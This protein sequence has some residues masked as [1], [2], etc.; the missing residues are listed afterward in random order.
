MMEVFEEAFPIAGESVLLKIGKRER[1]GVVDADQSGDVPVEF[2]AEPLCKTP[3]CPIPAWAGRRLNL[4]RFA[5]VLGQEHADSLATGVCGLCAGVV[6]A[7]VSGEVGQSL[8]T[9]L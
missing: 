1:E 2:N 6:D 9:L 5:G 3:P 7:D 8:A 4:Y